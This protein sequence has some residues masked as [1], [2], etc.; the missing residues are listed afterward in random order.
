MYSN[1]AMP[2][3]CPQCGWR[4][5]RTYAQP[6]ALG[7]HRSQIV[8]WGVCVKC[9]TPMQRTSRGERAMSEAKAQRI[10]AEL[11]EWDARMRR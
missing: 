8:E 4:T 10:K 1:A 11:A 3:A 6:E 2:V 5:R 9:Q 7:W